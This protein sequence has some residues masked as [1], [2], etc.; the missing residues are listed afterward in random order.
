[1]ETDRND[2]FLA[3]ANYSMRIAP[4]NLLEIYRLI[5]RHI[6]S[7]AFGDYKVIIDSTIN[8]IVEFAHYSDPNIAIENFDEI[9]QNND[10]FPKIVEVAQWLD[11]AFQAVFGYLHKSGEYRSEYCYG[12][13]TED[14]RFREKRTD[15]FGIE[16]FTGAKRLKC[17]EC[18]Q[19]F[20]VHPTFRT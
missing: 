17:N 9:F 8:N 15:L 20:F 2:I 5:E 4:E 3:Y 16:Q 7:D 18:H 1:M 12:P 11:S 14:C 6:I 13:C 19:L 10:S